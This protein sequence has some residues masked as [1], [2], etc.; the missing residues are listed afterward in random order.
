MVPDMI[1]MTL[2]V[3]DIP[4]IEGNAFNQILYCLINSI[5]T[6]S[7]L[8]LHWRYLKVQQA[9]PLTTLMERYMSVT[10]SLSVV[11]LHFNPVRELISK[12]N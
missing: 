11:V 1:D 5:I 9:C 4:L 7:H 2:Y 10:C 8:C 6:Q 3:L 12:S